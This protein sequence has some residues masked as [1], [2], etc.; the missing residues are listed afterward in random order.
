MTIARSSDKA[1]REGCAWRKRECWAVAAS[2]SDWTSGSLGTGPR[3]GL[4]GPSLPHST[5]SETRGHHHERV[6]GVKLSLLSYIRP[7]EGNPVSIVNAKGSLLVE[8]QNLDSA[9]GKT[10]ENSTDHLG[11]VAGQVR[12]REMLR[13]SWVLPASMS[14]TIKPDQHLVLT[15]GKWSD[16]PAKQACCPSSGRRGGGVFPAWLYSTILHIL[17]WTLTARLKA[18][19]LRFVFS[20]LKLQ[21]IGGSIFSIVFSSTESI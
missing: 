19:D 12:V 11:E 10:W 20:F 7:S 16:P 8:W 18:I 17:K 4:W 6:K 2:A 1:D 21:E 5:A 13:P 15:P 14:P 3:G 9:S